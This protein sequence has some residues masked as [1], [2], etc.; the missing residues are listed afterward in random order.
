MIFITRLISYKD[1]NSFSGCDVV[2][3]AQMAPI[4]TETKTID[5]DF[6]TLGSLQT[7]SYSTH[8]DR[9]PIRA[10][11]NINAKDYVQGQRTIAGTMV[12]A[13]FNEHWMTPLLKE[14]ESKKC[15]SNTDIWSDELPALNLT[16]TMA[17]EYGHKSNMVMYGVKF[18]DDGGVMSINDLYTENTLQYVATGIQPLRSSGFKEHGYNSKGSPFKISEYTPTE[19]SWT[20]SGIQTYAKEWSGEYRDI[21]IVNMAGLSSTYA[22]DGGIIVTI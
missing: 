15:V 9:A 5:F 17:N 2:V 19:R 3:S 1:Y 16:I 22:N 21:I 8:Q 7:I 10:I 6:H 14:L 20:W 11:G 4:T 12:F 18:I 13:M